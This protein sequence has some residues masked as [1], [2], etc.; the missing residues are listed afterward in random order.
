MNSGLLNGLTS[1]APRTGRAVLTRRQTLS[2]ARQAQAR[3]NLGT[4]NGVTAA[5]RAYAVATFITETELNVAVVKGATYRITYAAFF[6]DDGASATLESQLLFPA[7]VTRATGCGSGTGASTIVPLTALTDGTTPANICIV[8]LDDSYL[9]ATFSLVLT[10]GVDGTIQ[11][12]WKPTTAN[13]ITLQSGATVR[14][15]RIA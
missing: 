13:T 14:A 4:F 9:F 1:T 8:A 2:A 15:E 5:D 10:A 6:L 3:V 12:Q 11:F 7:S